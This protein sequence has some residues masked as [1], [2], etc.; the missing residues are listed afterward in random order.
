MW[1]GEV[2]YWVKHLLCRCED[3]SSQN[4]HKSQVLSYISVTATLPRGD[5]R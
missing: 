2:T 5:G 4:P 1:G 3:L